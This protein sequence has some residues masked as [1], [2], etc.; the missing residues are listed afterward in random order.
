MQDGRATGQSTARAPN[1]KPRPT[2]SNSRRRAAP[3]TWLS[4]RL[5]GSV[6]KQQEHVADIHGAVPVEVGGAGRFAAAGFCCSAQVCVIVPDC[7]PAKPACD[8]DDD[9]SVGGVTDFLLLLGNWGVTRPPTW[10]TTAVEVGDFLEVVGRWGPCQYSNAARTGVTGYPLAGG[11]PSPRPASESQPLPGMAKG[12]S[13]SDA[14]VHDVLFDLGWSAIEK[15]ID[16]DEGRPRRPGL[17]ARWKLRSAI[18][19]FTRV[20]EINPENHAAMWA[21]GKIH[22]RL[23]SDAK[24]LSW[25]EHALGCNPRH[26]DYAREAALSA[27]QLGDAQRAIRYSNAATS[28]RPDDHGLVANLALAHLIAGDPASALTR[29]EEASRRAPHDDISAHVL[30]VV[31]QVLAGRRPCP[32]SLRDL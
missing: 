9:G 31:R 28:L 11:R 3:T 7:S 12:L 6:G 25:F 15:H 8:L 21:L 30:S 18:R 1:C 26:P 17:I 24:A 27:L 13:N 2:R 10:T 23:E 20:L 19:D 16:L 14:R 22:Q 4:A 32:R 5:S 29:A